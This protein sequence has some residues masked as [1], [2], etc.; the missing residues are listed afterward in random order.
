[1]SSLTSFSSSLHG[2]VR[3]RPLLM[4]RAS[5]RNDFFAPHEEHSGAL[6]N[7]WMHSIFWADASLLSTKKLDA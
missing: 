1:M 6:C 4:F 7:E 2:I 5:V 3:Q